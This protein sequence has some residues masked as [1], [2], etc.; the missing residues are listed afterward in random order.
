MW[1]RGA[2]SA[3]RLA[4]FTGCP[5]RLPVQVAL[6]Q[7]GGRLVVAVCSRDDLATCDRL[8]SVAP[9]VCPPGWCGNWDAVCVLI[10]G[11]D[12]FCVR[13]SGLHLSDE[14]VDR[15]ASYS[16]RDRER[17]R[18]GTVNPMVD[19]RSVAGEPIARPTTTAA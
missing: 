1:P 18:R 13:P 17:I 4:R 6:P 2:A 16:G 3:S 7:I 9:E 19:W 12:G 5:Y 11:G 15:Y 10:A 14:T 8:P